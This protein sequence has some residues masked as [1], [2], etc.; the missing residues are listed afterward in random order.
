[1]VDALTT[2][3]P[4]LPCLGHPTARHLEPLPS[5]QPWTRPDALVVMEGLPGQPE[6]RRGAL[7]RAPRMLLARQ[8]VQALLSERRAIPLTRDLY[9][10]LPEEQVAFLLLLDD[11]EAAPAACF[12]R[13]PD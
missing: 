12:A 6:E 2:I 8:D 1:M 5:A 7:I 11:P 3:L 13:G 10:P 9:P 4:S